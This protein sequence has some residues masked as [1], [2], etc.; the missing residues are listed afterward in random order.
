MF[1]NV[2]LRPRRRGALAVSISLHL[3]LGGTVWV[4]PLL[5]TQE[6]PEVPDRPIV[7]DLPR[8]EQP[9]D[10]TLV[11][12]A[13]P[14]GGG[15]GG[16]APRPLIQ[17]S[18]PARPAVV[19]PTEIPTTLPPESSTPEVAGEPPGLYEIDP[20]ETVGDQTKGP[21]L[22]GGCETCPI[23]PVGRPDVT[24]PVVLFSPDPVYPEAARRAHLQGR[25]ILEAI[26]GVDGAVRDVR[27]L[28]SA[29]PLLDQAAM[30][31]VLRWRYQPAR[32]GSREV[33]VY[34]NVSIGFSLTAR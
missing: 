23:S 25:V 13:R 34:L 29:N 4:R 6:P 1:E 17:R 2:S 28:R 12:A 32:V 24:L 20:P 18:R 27:V 11:Q 22:P 33:A 14:G 5:A 16:G 10:V 31:A 15:G 7:W 3:A 21:G 26:I 8:P 19:Q 9:I 30:D